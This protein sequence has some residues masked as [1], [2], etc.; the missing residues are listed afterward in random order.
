MES[1]G[2]LCSYMASICSRYEIKYVIVMVMYRVHSNRTLFL[3]RLC[4]GT[5]GNLPEVSLI[6]EISRI[7]SF[8]LLPR[9]V[10]STKRRRVISRFRVAMPKTTRGEAGCLPST[11]TEG[12]CHIWHVEAVILLSAFFMLPSH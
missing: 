8:L 2:I 10:A 3:R 12:P 11:D 5:E 6:E 9:P 7:L 1:K 4:P